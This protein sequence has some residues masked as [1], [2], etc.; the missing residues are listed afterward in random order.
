MEHQF[1]NWIWLDVVPG[2]ELFQQTVFSRT[3]NSFV[4]SAPKLL[5]QLFKLSKYW[6]GLLACTKQ[7][8]RNTMEHQSAN[9]D[10]YWAMFLLC[11]ETM[12]NPVQMPVTRQRLHR[13]SWE[14]LLSGEWQTFACRSLTKCVSSHYFKSLSAQI[15][16]WQCKSFTTAIRTS[17]SHLD[18]VTTQF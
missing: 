14:P 13:R 2:M 6:P 4:A 15:K 17:F 3:Q 5:P 10:L 9:Y 7:P 16:F 8:T 18:K 12:C 11:H 1:E